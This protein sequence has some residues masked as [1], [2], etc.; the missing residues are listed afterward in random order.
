MMSHLIL[1]MSAAI[2]YKFANAVSV[3]PKPACR[4]YVTREL[5]AS[6]EGLVLRI[7]FLEQVAQAS[8]AH[9]AYQSSS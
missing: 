9:A 1:C 8:K 3:A 6:M 4:V 5:K 2:A 7:A